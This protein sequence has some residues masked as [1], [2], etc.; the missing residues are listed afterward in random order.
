MK[1]VALTL[2]LIAA[3]LPASARAQTPGL[4]VSYV[5]SMPEPATHLFTVRMRV[6]NI[7]AGA[8]HVDLVMPV[9]TPGSYLV[10][11]FARNVQDFAT[12]AQA[13][14]ATPRWEKIDKN[15]WRVYEPGPAI[16]VAYRVYANELTVRTSHLDD[17]HGY[18]NGASVFMYVDGHDDRPL[19]LVI[20]APRGWDASTGLARDAGRPG[21]AFIAPNYDVFVDAPIEIGTHRKIAFEALGKPHEIAIWGRGNFDATRLRDD[22]KKIVE[23][24]AAIFGNTVPYDRYVFIVHVFSG[25][26]GGLEHLNSTSLQAQPFV[27]TKKEG[28]RGFL[29]LVAHEFFHLW[30]VKRIRPEALGPFDYE[31]EN[32]TKMLWLMEGTTDFYAPVILRRAG[33][34]TEEDYNKELAKEIQELQNTPGRRHLSL[35]EASFDTWIKFYRQN[36]HSVNSQVSYYLKGSVVSAMLDL[37][38]RGRTGGKK[39]LDDVMRHLYEAY[40]LKGAGVPENAVQPAVEAVAGSSFEEF[41]DR[42]VRGTAEMDYNAFLAHAGL[43]LVTEVKKDDARLDPAQKAGW[44]GATV[45]DVNGQTIVRAVLEGSPAWTH[46]LGAN[47]QLLALDGMRVTAATLEERLADSKPGAAVELVVFRRDELRRLRVVLGERPVD[48]YKIEKIVPEKKTGDDR[49]SGGDGRKER[50]GGR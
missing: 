5:L 9:W 14:G 33:L 41:F 24:S 48:S 34:M 12:V 36:E 44:L 10:R 25:G 16:E 7:Q 37:E 28:Y 49:K 43:K 22:V 45:A 19:S 17:T 6:A 3:L 26:G 1:T 13:G 23:A 27:F 15:T 40:A 8:P 35:E 32:Y 30:N 18:V 46:G 21:L 11:E 42:Y 50:G 2:L 47:D 4:E 38:I 39:S 20:E 31:A 29:S